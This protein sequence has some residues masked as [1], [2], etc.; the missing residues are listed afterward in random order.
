M[1][2]SKQEALLVA[3]DIEHVGSSKGALS[4][5]L[6]VNRRLIGADFP[7]DSQLFETKKQGQ[8]KGLGGGVVRK[9][10]AHMVSQEC[11][12]KRVAGPAEAIWSACAPTWR[13]L[14]LCN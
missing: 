10:F 8:V 12:L 11:F 2:V 9:F 13:W 14:T 5:V 4:M 6:V 1:T 7:V 3:F